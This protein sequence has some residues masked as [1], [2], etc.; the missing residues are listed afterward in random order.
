MKLTSLILL[1]I[2]LS[3][4]VSR[5]DRLVLNQNFLSIGEIVEIEGR[6]Y[7]DLATTVCLEREYVYSLEF[8]GPLDRFKV[9]DVKKCDR[10]TG[11]RPRPYADQFNFLD[12]VRKEILENSVEGL[13]GSATN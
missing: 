9:V 6:R 4:C 3:S 7:V 12:D 5:P 13:D 11:M 1:T 2:C 10:I 8:F